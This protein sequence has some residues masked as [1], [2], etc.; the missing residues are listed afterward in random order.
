MYIS[1]HSSFFSY[2]H[3]FWTQVVKESGWFT[4]LNGSYHDMG[5]LPCSFSPRV[6]ARLGCPSSSGQGQK[7]N[8]LVNFFFFLTIFCCLSSMQQLS[9][10][11]WMWKSFLPGAHWPLLG[12]TV[13]NS[14]YGTSTCS[15]TAAAAHVVC[16]YALKDEWEAFAKRWGSK[17][18]LYS[19]G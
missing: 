7:N 17:K 10:I 9:V 16:E 15:W 5:S 12:A 6:V 8:G 18:E 2:L 3:F 1:C 4:T 13:Q 11:I 19:G 14:K